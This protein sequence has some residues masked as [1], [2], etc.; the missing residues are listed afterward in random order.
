MCRKYVSTSFT[1]RP[2]NARLLWDIVGLLYTP[3]GVYSMDVETSLFDFDVHWRC[4]CLETIPKAFGGSIGLA[5]NHLSVP[6]QLVSM[7]K[8]PPKMS[9]CLRSR[10]GM[11][12]YHNGDFRIGGGPFFYLTLNM[13]LRS[14][15]WRLK[16]N[17]LS[18]LILM[19]FESA[20]YF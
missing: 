16:D 18:F 5:N 13:R 8:L 11:E 15:L 6:S 12:S 9:L 3:N 17:S 2:V 4:Y 1:D 20:Q 14:F 7:Y 10:E 19:L